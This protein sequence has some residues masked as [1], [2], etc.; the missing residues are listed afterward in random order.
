MKRDAQTREKGPRRPRAATRTP[1]AVSNPRATRTPGL[2]R[3]DGGER[4]RRPPR[5]RRPSSTPVGARPEPRNPGRAV[6]PRSAVTRRH[7]PQTRPTGVTVGQTLRTARRRGATAR[8]RHGRPGSRTGGQSHQQVAA[9]RPGGARQLVDEHHLRGTLNRSSRPRQGRAPLGVQ[10]G[11]P[12]HA[13]RRAHGL[14][15]ALVRH[16]ITAASTT[17]GSSPS[18]PLDLVR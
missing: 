7:D 13:P 5:V 6:T 14:A 16:P 4:V 11:G 18:T 17:S 2:D 1:F 8:A 10:L 9:S 12:E 3:C 15:R